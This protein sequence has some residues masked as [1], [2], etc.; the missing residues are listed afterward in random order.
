VLLNFHE[1][2]LTLDDL[3]EIWM[4]S[5]LEEVEGPQPKERIITVAKLTDGLGLID[6]GI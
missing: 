6:A 2:K 1:Q 5:A 4:Q 3:A